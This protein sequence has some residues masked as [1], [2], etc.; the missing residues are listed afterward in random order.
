MKMSKTC[1]LPALFLALLT[2]YSCHRTAPESLSNMNDSASYAYGVLLG[3]GLI[4][5]ELDDVIDIE[6][7]K[8]G[9]ADILTGANDTFEMQEAREI[10]GEF[11]E[12]NEARIKMEKYGDNLRAGEKFLKENSR[13]KEVITTKSGLQYEILK[14]GN[15]P[16]PDTN[17]VVH[18]H[19][20]GTLIDG[21]LIDSSG[22]KPSVFAVDKVIPGWTEALQLMKEGA[23]W[24]VYV[25]HELA[26][27]DMD[28]PSRNIPPYSTLVFEIELVKV[29]PRD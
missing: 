14:K 9:M 25:P 2:G 29:D 18:V 19:Y 27:H 4:G 21:T 11:W 26:Y 8:K 28:I 7:V 3:H 15:G 6:L 22:E 24:K 20:K 5:Q 23:R 13:R 1:F 12:V 10:M 17:D 16:V